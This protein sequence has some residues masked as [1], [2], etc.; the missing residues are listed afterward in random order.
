MDVVKA[1]FNKY[2]RVLAEIEE[3]LKQGNFNEALELARREAEATGCDACEIGFNE[4]STQL[5]VASGFCP[6]SPNCNLVMKKVVE[7]L[8]D[9]KKTFDPENL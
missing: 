4:L 9:L 3:N 5:A 7:K 2:Q 8:E 6:V 1:I